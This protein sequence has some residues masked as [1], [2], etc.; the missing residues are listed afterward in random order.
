MH[1]S[2]GVISYGGDTRS[3]SIA[4]GEG[5]KASYLGCYTDDQEHSAI[6]DGEFDH[7]FTSPEA[8]LQVPEWTNF[9]LCTDDLIAIAIDEA[10]CIVYARV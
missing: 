4:E 8:I 6:V 3:G 7:L 9:L 1:D 2:S 5:C 10:H